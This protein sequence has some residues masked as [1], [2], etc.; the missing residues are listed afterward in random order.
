MEPPK[1]QSESCKEAML[2]TNKASHV[3]SKLGSHQK[4]SPTIRI[5]HIFAPKIIK[6]DAANFRS[7][8][9]KLTGR[10]SGRSKTSGDR[11]SKAKKN[12]TT[13]LGS[14]VSPTLESPQAAATDQSEER[15]GDLYCAKQQEKTE[16]M[17]FPDQFF[18]RVPLAEVK[19][20]IL[21]DSGTNPFD[22]LF[23]GFDDL[24][25][26][27]GLINSAPALPDFPTV[28]PSLTTHGYDQNDQNNGLFRSSEYMFPGE[29]NYN[30]YL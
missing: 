23:G 9:Q 14:S 13:A 19:T 24:D 20:E 26:F 3:I 18:P 27:T 15:P 21:E 11:V 4:I 7:L 5:V 2:G 28:N 29:Y 8:V 12:R 6:T 16:F 30:Y 10:P 1:C 17:C 25:I 22:N